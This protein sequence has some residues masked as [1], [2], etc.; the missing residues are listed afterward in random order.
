AGN[1]TELKQMLR[2][3]QQEAPETGEAAAVQAN[4]AVPGVADGAPASFQPPGQPGQAPATDYQ[5]P[6]TE[7]QQQPPTQYPPQSGGP[8]ES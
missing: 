1:R 3:A 7:Y 8:G 5:Q 4:V 6:P 2:R